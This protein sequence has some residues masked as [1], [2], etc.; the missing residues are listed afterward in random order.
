MF[1]VQVPPMTLPRLWKH[2][3]A[4][5][6]ANLERLGH[7]C[8]RWGE[9]HTTVNAAPGHPDRTLMVRQLPPWFENLG[10][11]QVKSPKVYLRDTESCMSCWGWTRFAVGGPPESRRGRGG[12]R[13]R[14]GL[15]R[16]GRPAAYF[17]G[18]H[19]GHENWNLLVF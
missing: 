18:T 15:A 6:R 1:G 13:H 11:R 19:S 8:A 14:E 4:L 16:D 10:K 12:V 17:W 5:S 3:G 9:A 2:A 7:L